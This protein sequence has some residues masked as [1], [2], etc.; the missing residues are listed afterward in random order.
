MKRTEFDL[1]AIHAYRYECV[2]P[3]YALLIVHGGGGWGGMYDNFAYPYGERNVDIWSLDLPGFGQSGRRG[4]FTA[5]EQHEAVAR[6][7][8]EIRARHDRP[9]F[10]LG[11]SMG[12]YYSSAASFLPEV[13]GVV[14][15][16]SYLLCGD[17]G[18]LTGLVAEPAVQQ[19]L[20]A[21]RI[22]DCFYL[23]V[24]Q[25]IDWEKDYGDA[26]MGRKFQADPNHTGR[27]SMKSWASMYTW[28]PPGD[29][30]DNAVPFLFIVAARDVLAP[31]EAVRSAYDSVGGPKELE[32]IDSD[33]HQVM[34]FHREEYSDA[35][36]DW[37]RRQVAS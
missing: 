1:D 27:M 20:N 3:D 32:I 5:D 15:S 21:P 6:L 2:E 12:G 26:E 8:R 23:D 36:D 4:V 22:G 24:D 29:L 9:I 30:A 34:L 33:K 14:V 35:L 25:M 16:A 18:P 37:C 19:L 17:L 31:M 10:V 28:Q 11:S 7:V 13:A